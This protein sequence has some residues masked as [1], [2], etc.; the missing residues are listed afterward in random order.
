MFCLRIAGL[1]APKTLYF[2]QTLIVLHHY[3]RIATMAEVKQDL[4]QFM[5]AVSKLKVSK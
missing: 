4:L 1:F 3:K 2:R 5:T